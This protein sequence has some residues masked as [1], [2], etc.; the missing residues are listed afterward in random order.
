[1]DQQGAK[2]TGV[3]QNETAETSRR[4]WSL[5]PYELPF[6]VGLFEPPSYGSTESAQRDGARSPARATRGVALQQLFCW[7]GLA[8]A[9]GPL[10]GDTDRWARA[11]ISGRAGCL[12]VEMND[13]SGTFFGN[14]WGRGGSNC[15]PLDN[16]AAAP[17]PKWKT[18]FRV[19]RCCKSCHVSLGEGR[20]RFLK[21]TDRDE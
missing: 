3:A 21:G 12:N 2:H 15:P 10:A 19:Q 18:W 9:I 11:R 4:V 5:F 16:S 17:T 6:W 7:L 1:M 14:M 20:F 13:F 8:V